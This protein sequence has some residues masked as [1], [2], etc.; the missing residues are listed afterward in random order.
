MTLSGP[1]VVS[2]LVKTAGAWVEIESST[3]EA[4][5]TARCLL[6]S[7]RKAIEKAGRSVPPALVLALR[8]VTAAKAE[9]ERQEGA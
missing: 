1:G 3:A 8:T 2:L 9:L 5:E 4:A 6:D 7:A